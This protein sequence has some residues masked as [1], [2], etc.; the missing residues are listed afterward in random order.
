L[1]EEPAN[2]G[3]WNY[4]RPRLR[5]LLNGLKL[6]T[7]IAI[8]YCGR[9]ESASTAEGSHEQ[10]ENEQERILHEAVYGPV[11]RHIMSR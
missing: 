11:D 5:E 7:P 2:M 4:I 8:R 9:A 6:R 1:Q 3:A 10:H